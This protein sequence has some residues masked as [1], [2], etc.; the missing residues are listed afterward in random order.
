MK[1][2]DQKTLFTSEDHLQAKKQLPPS[3]AVGVEVAGKRGATVG[4]EGRA[5]ELSNGDVV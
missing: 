1:Y 2:S 5:L 3:D 4:I